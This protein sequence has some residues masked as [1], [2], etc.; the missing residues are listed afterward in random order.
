MRKFD[1]EKF[2]IDR[3]HLLKYC[4]EGLRDIIYTAPIHA[5]LKVAENKY[6]ERMK[7]AR[8]KKLGD[9]LRPPSQGKFVRK[10]NSAQRTKW[11]LT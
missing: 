11:N 1:Y 5:K 8:E 3:D 7:E 4:G 10:T 2:S 6:L 9:N